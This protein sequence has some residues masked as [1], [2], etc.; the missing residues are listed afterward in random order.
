MVTVLSCSISSTAG[1]ELNVDTA[2][3]G[4]EAVTAR[5]SLCSCVIVPTYIR[6]LYFKV[7]TAFAF[8]VIF[9]STVRLD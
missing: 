4:N 7:L 3:S 9:D 8:N 1:W 2:S 6:F 5:T